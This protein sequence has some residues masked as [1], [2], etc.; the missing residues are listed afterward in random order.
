MCFPLSKVPLQ[1]YKDGA[2]RFGSSRGKRLH[3]GCDLYAPV[4]TPILAV[5]DG[6][7]T[8][9]SSTF[10][11]GTGALE[12]RHTHFIGRYC[13]ISGVA[14]G[15]KQGV[16]VKEGQVIAYVGKLRNISQSMLHFEMYAGI[17][18]RGRRYTIESLTDVKNPPYKRRNDLLDPTP[19]LDRWVHDLRYGV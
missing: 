12:I 1:S 15:I 14:H 6:V 8:K 3:A 7:V 9:Y 19:Y 13:E 18:S 17:D 5:A 4:G 10:Y 11:Q 16:A 2:R